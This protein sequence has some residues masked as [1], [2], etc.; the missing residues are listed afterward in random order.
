[1]TEETRKAGSLLCHPTTKSRGL[2]AV[3]VHNKMLS[4]HV[5]LVKR[6]IFRPYFLWTSFCSQYL[7]HS[8]PGQIRYGCSPSVLSICD[9]GLICSAADVCGQ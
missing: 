1:M 3:D 7:K 4:L 6:L 5:L 2:G 8:F 9:D